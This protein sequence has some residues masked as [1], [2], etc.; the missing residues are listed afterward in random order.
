[1][2][3]VR[4]KR[5]LATGVP[6]HGRFR[7]TKSTGIPHSYCCLPSS[8]RNN[9]SILDFHVVGKI[10]CWNHSKILVFFLNMLI[11]KSNYDRSHK[12]AIQRKKKHQALLNWWSY[13]KTLYNGR[14]HLKNYV[15]TQQGH[16]ENAH[17]KSTTR[18]QCREV[19]ALSPCGS[20]C[21]PCC[22]SLRLCSYRSRSAILPGP[23]GRHWHLQAVN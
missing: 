22:A 3:S 16:G 21:K 4:R 10:T 23:S 1:M 11:I 2:G 12:V 13:Y 9:V 15:V 8:A 6:G 20:G 14:E 5:V 7:Q 19:E 18:T 17:L